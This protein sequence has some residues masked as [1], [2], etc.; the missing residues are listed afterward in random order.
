MKF[1][2]PLYENEELAYEDVFLFQNYFEG[3][4]RLDI[5]V[6][7]EISLNTHIPIVVANMNA[8]AGKRMAETMARYGW[9]VVLP[10]DMDID[11]MKR[12][13]LHIKQANIFY[14]T[15]ITVEATHTIRDAMG[16]MYKR[17]HQCVILVDEEKKPITLFK[18][19]DF[20]WYDQFTLLGNL[21]KWPAIVAQEGISDEEAFDLME[22][23]SVSVL[24]IIDKKW[25][26]VGVLTK[27]Q[28]IRNS[29]YQP[30]LDK[31][32]NLDVAVALGINNFE[33]KAKILFDLGVTTFVLDTAH[34]YQKYM[35]EA[36]K[37][38]RAL[39][40]DKVK[41]V[42]GNVI[43]EAATKALLEAWADGVKVGI[44][45]GA[46]CTTRM[47]TWV[48]RPQFTAVYKCVQ[49]AKKYGWFVWADGGIKEPRDM[50]LALAAWA[51][52]VMRGTLW[53]GTYEAVGDI[54]YDQEW[55]M[56][57]ENYGMASQKAVSLRNKQISK[58]D[59]AR[60]QMFREWISTSKIYLKQ[61]RTSVGEI[62]D[63]FIAWL[64]SAMTY[65]WAS[66]LSEFH[67]NAIIG[68]QT[69]A[70][71]FEWTPH[72]KVKK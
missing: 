35:I 36:I 44:W 3:K 42:A 23:H 5:D 58:F 48:G 59:S 32:G 51:N 13:I 40:W 22:Q 43:T 46:M 30:T 53:A 61:G 1:N 8:V 28:T 2:N 70:G 6:N 24:P 12:I 67:E 55:H 39:F 52:H 65:V 14:D 15:P 21:S 41:I 38:C 56:Y 16:I 17:A 64:R 9:L 47:K 50:I 25:V 45:P 7:P 20:T 29:I 26:L 27:K 60:K 33:D 69:Q 11:T 49:E 62:V 68:V 19:K 57:K 72:G 37:R 66:N 31:Q 4:S 34:G 71:F 18:P 63:E 54:Q 10:Q